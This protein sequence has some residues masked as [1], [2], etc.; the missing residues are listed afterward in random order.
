[1]LFRESRDDG[2]TENLHVPM[3]PVMGTLVKGI[4]H[5][6]RNRGCWRDGGLGY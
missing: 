6:Q 2:L 4:L 3:F 5:A 1:V